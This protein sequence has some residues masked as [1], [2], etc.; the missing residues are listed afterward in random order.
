[1]IK[2]R[3]LTVFQPNILVV[4]IYGCNLNC[5]SCFVNKD[6]ANFNLYRL[7][8]LVDE[9]IKIISNFSERPIV[10]LSGGEP[11]IEL[12]NM[13]KLITQID[14]R[15]PIVQ[16]YIIETNGIVSPSKW[17]LHD[18]FINSHKL[19]IHISPKLKNR[20]STNIGIASQAR[21]L[22]GCFVYLIKRKF[23]RFLLSFMIENVE[24]LSDVFDFMN[25][26]ISHVKTRMKLDNDFI[27]KFFKE[28]TRMYCIGNYF[29]PMTSETCNEILREYNKIVLINPW[30]NC[31]FD[32]D[33]FPQNLDKL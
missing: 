8:D 5:R 27:F 22:A 33:N 29:N 24:D 13:K 11:S 23:K 1:M 28:H 4:N 6:E 16:K 25:K 10:V 18:D 17:L 21:T 9:C 30:F 20:T 2:I 31:F 15:L 26:S 14:D 7:E 32:L 3:S 12:I 19:R